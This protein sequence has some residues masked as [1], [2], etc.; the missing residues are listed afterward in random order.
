MMLMAEPPVLVAPEPA[1]AAG[2]ETITVTGREETL[3]K[4]AREFTR[5]VLPVPALGQ[6]ASWASPICV[7]V[8]GVEDDI[9]ARVRLRIE[10]IA[11]EAGA[12]VAAAPCR[13][14]LTVAFAGNG[15]EMVRDMVRRRP[16][17]LAGFQP[18]DVQQI[19]DV[20]KPVTWWRSHTPTSAQGGAADSS[21]AAIASALSDS[22]VPLHSMLPMGADTIMTSAYRSTL[23]STNLALSVT[24][25][26]A[27]VDVE[28]AEGRSLDAVADYVALVTL[29]PIRSPVE[30]S[31]APSILNLFRGED[32]GPD[33][34]GWDRALLAASFR[35]T[36]DR[37]ARRQKAQL[38]NGMVEALTDGEP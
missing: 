38:Q 33:L 4:Q 7:G 23:I 22:G 11:K 31:A 16:R 13:T 3:R 28:M 35:F 37:T 21:S 5:Q 32:T 15:Q 2:Q 14:N 10:G 24:S 12:A 26:V 6:F 29:A 34:T 17:L 30:P 25:A 1:G 18:D 36:P 9:A 20:R 8:V 19:R 27:I